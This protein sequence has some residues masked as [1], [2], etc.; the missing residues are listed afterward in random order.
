MRSMG[1]VGVERKRDRSLELEAERCVGWKQQPRESGH[2]EQKLTK[3]KLKAAV[4]QKRVT[5]GVFRSDHFGVSHNQLGLE[6]QPLLTWSLLHKLN[7]PVTE[8]W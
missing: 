7:F 8:N 6:H 5:R 1:N 3:W 2:W 4:D